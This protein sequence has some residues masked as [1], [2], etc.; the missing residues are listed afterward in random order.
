[1]CIGNLFP[2]NLT[3]STLVFTS[4]SRHND[5]M[6]LNVTLVNDEVAEYNEIFYISLSTLDP[7]VILVNNMT[8]ITIEDDDSQLL[9]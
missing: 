5:S 9:L 8:T 2:D 1:M 7:N 4:G 3:S 6:C